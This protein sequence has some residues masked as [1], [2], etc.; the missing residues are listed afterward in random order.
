MRQQTNVPDTQGFPICFHHPVARE[1]GESPLSSKLLPTQSAQAGGSHETES[2]ARRAGQAGTDQ[3]GYTRR[4]GRC[5]GL[6]AE[7]QGPP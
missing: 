6:P 3:P 7:A 1:T 4:D 2:G 5:P